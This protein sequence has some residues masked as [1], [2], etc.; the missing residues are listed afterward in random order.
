VKLADITK[1]VVAVLIIIVTGILCFF[2]KIQNEAVTALLGAVVG[3]VLG[4]ATGIL[5]TNGTLGKKLQDHIDN[6]Q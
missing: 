3:Y 5:Q 6:T 1:L 4:N 2:G